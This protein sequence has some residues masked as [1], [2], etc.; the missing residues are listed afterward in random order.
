MGK[1]RGRDRRDDEGGEKRPIFL[2]SATCLES[3]LLSPA[4][5]PARNLSA[6][7]VA[8]FRSYPRHGDACREP[9]V[10]AG[11]KEIHQNGWDEGGKK[12]RP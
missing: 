3:T 11:E 7:F 10:L 8:I 9:T 2:L 5:F 12:E 1:E 4:P 6:L